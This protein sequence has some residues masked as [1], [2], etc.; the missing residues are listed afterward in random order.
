I[1][2]SE[3]A[4][5]NPDVR[6]G[7]QRERSFLALQEWF[8]EQKLADLSP[9]YDFVSVRIGSQPFV[10]DFRGFIFNDVN[11]AVRLFGNLESNR[12]Q[13]NLA[14]FEQQ[15]KDTNSTLNT[16]GSRGQRIFIGNFFRHD[17]I[18][19][20][21]T[22]QASV[23]YNHDDPSFKFD[24]NNFLV[25]PAPVGTFQPHALDIVY[26]GFAG[27]GHINRVNISH[28]VYYALGH[29]TGNPL[30]NCPQDVSG[31][32]AALQLPYHRAP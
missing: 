24:K 1:A 29:D 20:G 15:E 2:V 19:P 11:R 16:L 8:Y 5:V 30:A 25:R 7:L 27:D 17:F 21:Y 31:L 3:L 23:H 6:R 10:S 26:L 28:Q 13:F 9:Y 18:W 12:D 4:V 22:M 14:Y 32:M